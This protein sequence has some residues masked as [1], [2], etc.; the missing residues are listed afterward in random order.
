[1]AGPNKDCGDLR[2]NKLV[3]RE[4]HGR[5]VRRPGDPRRW[6]SRAD[7]RVVPVRQSSDDGREESLVPASRMRLKTARAESR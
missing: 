5:H 7:P 1:M 3:T 4:R 2:A 6:S